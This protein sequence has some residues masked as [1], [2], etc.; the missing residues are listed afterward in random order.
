MYEAGVVV[1]LALW[2]AKVV[3]VFVQLNS[4]QQRNLNKVGK[5]LS[6]LT[7]TAK[8]LKKSDIDASI[9][10]K[11][12]KFFIIWLVIPFFLIFTSWVYVFFFLTGVIYSFYR[13]IGKPQEVKEF[14]WKLKNMDLSFDQIVDGFSQIA[15]LSLEDA[16][17]AKAHIKEQMKRDGLI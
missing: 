11:V 14:Q 9:T 5:R 2:I 16:T 6:W 1:A 4:V 10:L 12:F 8:P 13:N 7:L 15:G 3:F 17:E